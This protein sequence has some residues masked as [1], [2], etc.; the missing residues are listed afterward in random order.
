MSAVAVIAAN[1][2]YERQ[3]QVEKCNSFFN[4]YNH[5]TATVVDMQYYSQCAELLYPKVSEY[6]AEGIILIKVI[7]V[8]LLLLP[9][10]GAVK[11]HRQCWFEGAFTWFIF[12]AAALL[13]LYL[14]LAAI[15]Y[16][17]SG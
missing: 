6:S 9:I 11:N 15:L 7:L 4:H 12:G 5:T 8:Y 14:V 16:I 17:I 1:R 3:K 2:E 13:S 10:I